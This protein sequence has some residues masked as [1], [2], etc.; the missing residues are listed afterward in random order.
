MMEKQGEIREGL[1]PPQDTTDQKQADQ[2]QQDLA[3]HLTKRAAD[4]A[5]E[6]KRAQPNK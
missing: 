4:A 3:D 5:A 1:T 6:S 2:K